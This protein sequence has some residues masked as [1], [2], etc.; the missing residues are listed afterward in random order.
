MLS[1]DFNLLVQILISA[2]NRYISKALG[3]KEKSFEEISQ[4]IESVLNNFDF[5][6]DVEE[7]LSESE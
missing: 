2:V 3:K 5:E 6:S 1:V 4:Y 7:N